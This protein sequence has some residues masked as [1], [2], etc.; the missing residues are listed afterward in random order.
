M[1]RKPNTTIAYGAVV[2]AL[3]TIL[4]AAIGLPMAVV[5][6]YD[7]GFGGAG[8]IGMLLGTYAICVGL[9]AGIL[10]LAGR[11]F[12]RGRSGRLS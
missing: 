8:Q 10:S 6:S 2:A 5:T 1:A 9:V 4:W 3:G 12:G 7:M 11:R